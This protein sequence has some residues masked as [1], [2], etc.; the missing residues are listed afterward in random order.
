MNEKQR[1]IFIETLDQLDKM[2]MALEL[3]ALK[4]TDSA[5]LTAKEVLIEVGIWE[6][7]E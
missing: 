6:T 5:P 1:E 3:I 2:R 4:E 7:K